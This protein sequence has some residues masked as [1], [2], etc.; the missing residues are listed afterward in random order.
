VRQLGVFAK[1]WEPGAVKTR[2]AAAIGDRRASELYRLL[3]ATSLRRF[4]AAEDR[5]VLAFTP[6]DRQAGFLELAGPGWLLQ[7]QAEGDLGVRIKQYFVN[8][9]QGGADTV[10]LLGADSPTLPHAYLT[11]AFV[12]LEE[13]PVVLG[14]AQD[15]GYYLVGAR[16][17]VP[18][19]FDDVAWGSSQVWRQ[20]IALLQQADCPFAVLP[21]WYDVDEADDLIRLRSDLESRS[22][23]EQEGD[24]AEL[25]R[26]V[27]ELRLR[28]Q[29][30][31]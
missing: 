20:T 27:R 12:A 23:R 29:A 19:I 17:R 24:F 6:P 22:S 11:Q 7:P 15:G 16:D 21:E 9:F 8:A 5:H 25:L 4:A 28:P 14:P 13:R 10:V 30:V 18:P 26:A 2:L 1:Y 3:L 31:G